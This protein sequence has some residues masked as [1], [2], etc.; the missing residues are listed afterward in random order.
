[1]F[2]FIRDLGPAG[3]IGLAVGVGVVGYLAYSYFKPG[4][5][6]AATLPSGSKPSL[7]SAGGT[8]PKATSG[9]LT[10]LQ[11][12]QILNTWS[13]YTDL[14]W[15]LTVDNKLG[16]NTITAIKKFQGANSLPATG[17]LDDRTADALLAYLDYVQSQT[18]RA[19][20]PSGIDTSVSDTRNFY[21]SDDP[22]AHLSS[23]VL[24]RRPA[25]V[26]SIRGTY[27]RVG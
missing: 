20:A 1:M 15:T 9:K 25:Y 7:P 10:V 16:P 8:A 3:K 2:G 11:A 24:A 13:N 23:G 21:S 4:T 27:R 26:K 6:S 14:G 5:A 18:Q 22:S 19:Y 12:Q 17:N